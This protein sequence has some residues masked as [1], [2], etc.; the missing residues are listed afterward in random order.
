MHFI[1]DNPELDKEERYKDPEYE[2]WENEVTKEDT[3][4]NLSEFDGNDWEEVPVNDI[5]YPDMGK[6]VYN[7]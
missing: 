4:L 6:G 1:L 3:K 2:K 5:D 7:E